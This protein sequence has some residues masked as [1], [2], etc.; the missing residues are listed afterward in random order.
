MSTTSESHCETTITLYEYV[1]TIIS[2]RMK[3]NHEHDVARNPNGVCPKNHHEFA[4]K[5]EQMCSVKMRYETLVKVSTIHQPEQLL[6]IDK[7]AMKSTSEK[8]LLSH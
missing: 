4:F 2:K 7:N 8:W 1:A 3:L 6:F 5:N